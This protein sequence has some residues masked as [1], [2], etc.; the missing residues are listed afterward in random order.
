M[1]YKYE[2]IIVNKHFMQVLE[3]KNAEKYKCK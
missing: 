2:A 1:F 3:P